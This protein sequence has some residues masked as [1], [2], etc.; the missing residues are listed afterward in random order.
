MKREKKCVWGGGGGAL[1]ARPSLPVNLFACRLVGYIFF[2]LL[3]LNLRSL[4][5]RS[6][7]SNE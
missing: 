1:E 6:W 4:F 2:F 7:K 3:R 5:S